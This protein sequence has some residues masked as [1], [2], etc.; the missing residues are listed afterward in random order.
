MNVLEAND[1]ADHIESQ[2][3]K[4]YYLRQQNQLMKNQY[5]TMSTLVNI[6][7][8]VLDLAANSG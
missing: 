4:A 8:K 1:E 7:K 6:Y 3:C 2:N 5:E